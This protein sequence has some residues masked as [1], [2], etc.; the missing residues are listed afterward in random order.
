[1]Y[2]YLFLKKY[3]L[4]KYQSIMHKTGA[5]PGF[6]WGDPDHDRPKLPMVPSSVM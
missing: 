5:D 6:D 4:F 3:F 2:M 1:M